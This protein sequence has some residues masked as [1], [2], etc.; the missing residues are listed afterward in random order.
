MRWPNLLKYKKPPTIIFLKTVDPFYS[1]FSLCLAVQCLRP[2]APVH[3]GALDVPWQDEVCCDSP[4]A[5]AYIEEGTSQ[6]DLNLD[7]SP[8]CKFRS[9]SAESKPLVS[10]GGK[11]LCSKCCL[12]VWQWMKCSSKSILYDA[13][14]LTRLTPSGSPLCITVGLKYFFTCIY[15]LFNTKPTSGVILI[16][17]G[18]STQLYVHSP[19]NTN[20]NNHK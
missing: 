7:T 1:P 11:S 6:S 4:T 15:W 16:S 12:F 20:T 19:M 13:M 14:D 5:N 9:S 3:S 10:L 18:H 2:G 17:S 8:R